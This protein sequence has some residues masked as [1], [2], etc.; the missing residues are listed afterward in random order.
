AAHD[1]STVGDYLEY[2]YSPSIRAAV[3]ALL[4]VGSI[5]IL[6]GQL[7]AIGAI[8]E[9]VA[10]VPSIIGIITG[11]AVISAY[12][13]A[14]GLLSSARVNVLQLAIKLGGF[15]VAVPLA[16]AAFGGWHAVAQVRSN[17]GPYWSF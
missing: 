3:S 4:W 8:L 15:A 17:D 5:F 1:L 14:G 11:G 9:T 13:A 2:R 7:V 12:F 10:G 16:V 6:A